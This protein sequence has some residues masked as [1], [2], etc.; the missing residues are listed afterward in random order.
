MS[1]IDD[2]IAS[3]PPVLDHWGVLII[4]ILTVFES[5][6]FGFLIPGQTIAIAAG[7]LSKLGILNL[8]GVLIAS[9]AGSI[10]GDISSY[11]IGRNFG[12]PFIK[13]FGKYFLL[14]KKRF[15]ATKS[16]VQNHAG[17]ALFFGRFHAITKSFTS[18]I[19]GFS[20]IKFPKF[21]F[22]TVIGSVAWSLVFVLIG[23]VFGK[24]FEIL[25]ENLDLLLIILILF[26]I[27]AFL[28]YK[29][30]IKKRITY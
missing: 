26:I 13:R 28:V 30:I 1:L 4:L 21:L 15:E 20:H 5:F 9:I 6:P 16:L 18:F 12:L 11:Y 22:F 19:A 10:I 2:I 23:F 24:G 27:A 3:P 8:W 25:M 29:F 14:N 7:F 17:K